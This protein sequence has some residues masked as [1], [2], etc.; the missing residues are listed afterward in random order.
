MLIC[1]HSFA[2]SSLH[3]YFRTR[4]V[5]C[6]LCA[7]LAGTSSGRSLWHRTVQGLDTLAIGARPF[8]L[9][10]APVQDS[11]DPSAL[12]CSGPHL[13]RC[14]S[15]PA[16]GYSTAVMLRHT[17]LDFPGSRSLRQ[18]P[19]PPAVSHPN[20]ARPNLA[21]GLSKARSLLALGCSATLALDCS[22]IPLT[23]FSFASLFA[24]VSVCSAV[25][26]RLDARLLDARLLHR[27]V[28]LAQH[29][30]AQHSGAQLCRSVA[31]VTRRSLAL[32]C[33]GA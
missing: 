17:V 25:T 3:V 4:S 23:L 29:S 21:K 33:A 6:Q 1:S 13:L 24:C 14:S 31:H 27:S 18:G 28:V 12:G 20:V 7:L 16:L 5:A 2:H 30:G 9:S 11:S 8:Q 15:S 32:A 26:N 19:P 10:V 22:G